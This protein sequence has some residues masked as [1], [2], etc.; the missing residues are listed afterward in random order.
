MIAFEHYLEYYKKYKSSTIK[1]KLSA[2]AKLNEFLIH[3]SF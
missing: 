1:V 3:N 2:L